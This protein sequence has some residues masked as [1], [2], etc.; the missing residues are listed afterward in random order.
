MRRDAVSQRDFL[1]CAKKSAMAQNRIP[2]L[3]ADKAYL[4]QWPAADGFGAA[5]LTRRLLASAGSQPAPAS[6]AGTLTAL[7]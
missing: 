1:V 6:R 5:D 2:S 4:A 7:V 3:F